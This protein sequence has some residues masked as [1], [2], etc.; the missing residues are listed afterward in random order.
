MGDKGGGAWGLIIRSL[1]YSKNIMVY[2]WTFSLSLMSRSFWLAIFWNEINNS[3]KQKRALSMSMDFAWSTNGA[4][5]S[6]TQRCSNSLLNAAPSSPVFFIVVV[7]CCCCFFWQD[8]PLG[9]EVFFLFG[10]NEQPRSQGSLLPV[11]TERE[12][13]RTWERGC[14]GNSGSRSNSPA[15]EQDTVVK[16]PCISYR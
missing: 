16:V 6:R 13:E 10:G 5:I 11:T 3:E 15:G 2:K 4:T 9:P 1:R 14:Q 7:C 8:I 12:G